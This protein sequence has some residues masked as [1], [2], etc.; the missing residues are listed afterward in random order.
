[1]PSWG[2]YT[3]NHQEHYLNNLFF[4]LKNL[5]KTQERKLIEETWEWWFYTTVVSCNHSR[6][7]KWQIPMEN[8]VKKGGQCERIQF[9]EEYFVVHNLPERKEA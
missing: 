8:K 5:S 1:M 3:L 6:Q 7:G 9:D 2:L 4:F